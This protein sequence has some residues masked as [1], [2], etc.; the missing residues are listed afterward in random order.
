MKLSKS[1]LQAIVLG[2]AVGATTTS[3]SQ[4]E[5]ND[6]LLVE[7]C[8]EDCDIKCV[9]QHDDDTFSHENCPACGLG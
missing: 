1:L 6:D 3:C 9:L 7:K 5:D 2:A 8:S 4:F